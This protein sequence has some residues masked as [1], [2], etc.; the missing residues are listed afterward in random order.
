MR[1]SKQINLR[2]SDAESDALSAS[3]LAAG[4]PLSEWARCVLVSAV[5]PTLREQLE[6]AW[7][8]AHDP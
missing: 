4:L 6:R 3:A 8:A 7:G 1:R 5:D 2:L